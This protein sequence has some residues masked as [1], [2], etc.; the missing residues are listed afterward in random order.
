MSPLTSIYTA[1][2]VETQS[3]GDVEIVTTFGEPQAEY[4]SL[5]R[6]AGLI[7]LPFRGI[8]E[9]TRPRPAHISQ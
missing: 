2:N 4:A 9:V 7:D 3:Y 8:L 1:P 6:T 5:H